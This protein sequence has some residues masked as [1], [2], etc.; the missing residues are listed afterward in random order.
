MGRGVRWG[1]SGGEDVRR[2]VEMG[3]GVWWDGDGG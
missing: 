2:G 1:G 3:M